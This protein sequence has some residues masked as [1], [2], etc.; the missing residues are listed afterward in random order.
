MDLHYAGGRL[1][2]A[3]QASHSSSNDDAPAQLET[4]SFNFTV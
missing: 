4:T 2:G 1:F 3:D